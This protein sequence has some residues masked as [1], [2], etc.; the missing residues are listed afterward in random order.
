MWLLSLA[1]L[2]N[3]GRRKAVKSKNDVA[4]AAAHQAVLHQV[5]GDARDYTAHTGS[6][7]AAITDR[8]STSVRSA[9]AIQIRRSDSLISTVRPGP[10]K[11]GNPRLRHSANRLQPILY[12]EIACEIESILSIRLCFLLHR[13]LLDLCQR[14]NM[15]PLNW[16][17]APQ[18]ETVLF[19]LAMKW[20]T[21]CHDK[22]DD[23]VSFAKDS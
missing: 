18:N 9:F 7:S 3:L 22:R 8:E 5:Y 1:E 21:G 11:H 10:I 2:K 12:F 20:Q 15:H 19:E 13:P 4:A 16:H 23:P 14:I 17:R 6:R